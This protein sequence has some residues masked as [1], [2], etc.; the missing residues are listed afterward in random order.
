M[1]FRA[2]FTKLGKDAE[3]VTF[4]AR[5]LVEAIDTAE[6]FCS[7]FAADESFTMTPVTDKFP[8]SPQMPLEL[9]PDEPFN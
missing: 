9:L 3:R 7:L 1:I 4:G 6:L 2:Q 5:S 8:P